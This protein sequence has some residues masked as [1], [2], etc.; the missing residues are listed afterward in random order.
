MNL[1][2]SHRMCSVK[3][4]VLKLLKFHGKTPVLESLFNKVASLRLQHRCL[5]VKFVKFLRTSILKNICERKRITQ[6]VVFNFPND[7]KL[8]ASS[9]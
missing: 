3:R 8:S 2:S 4:G 7:V 5:P 1:R 9:N 6:C